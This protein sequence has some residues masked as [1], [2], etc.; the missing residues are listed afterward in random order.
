MFVGSNTRGALHGSVTGPEAVLRFCRSFSSA[1]VPH[2]NRPPL[3]ASSHRVKSKN[4]PVSTV[5]LVGKFGS[6]IGL[7]SGP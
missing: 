1:P 5:F 7:D 6:K 3:A 4:F 2:S